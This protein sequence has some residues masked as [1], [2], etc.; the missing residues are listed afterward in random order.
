ME[1]PRQ[2]VDEVKHINAEARKGERVPL[3]YNNGYPGEEPATHDNGD[4]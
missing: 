2:S 4:E 3:E 1:D